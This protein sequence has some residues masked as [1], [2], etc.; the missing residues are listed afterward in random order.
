MRTKSVIIKNVV[1]STVISAIMGFTLVIL[2]SCA[3]S[4]PIKIAY[5]NYSEYVLSS[6]NVQTEK[7]L[8]VEVEVLTPK[9]MYNHPELFSFD[10]MDMPS[11]W[12]LNLSRSYPEGSDG[13]SWLYTLGFGN[14][15]LTAMKVTITNKTGH[16]LRMK[17]SRIYLRIEGEDPIKA[18][19]HYGSS[20]LKEIEVATLTGTKMI[21]LPESYLNEDNSLIHWITHY[22][23]EWDKHRV[24]RLLE[25]S[26]PIGAA[27]QVLSANKK[28]YKLINDVD[29][30]I[31]PDDTYRGI[32]L[33]PVIVSFDQA[34]LKMYDLTT[35]TDA[36]GNPTEKVTFEF[37]LK[38][39]E[40][41]MWYDRD[42][43][44]WREGEPPAPA[45]T[46]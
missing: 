12:R 22:E 2:S 4:G 5:W 33:F 6:Q 21:K 36:A 15:F 31:L 7:G 42:Q 23:N 17:D 26:Y 3:S 39:N 18:L 37:K 24:K 40:D 27:S 11:N 10:L 14:N 13:K 34:T 41:K 38:L 29:R 30:E 35:Q 9:N 44:K 45:Q 25:L 32:L 19:T 1:F 46:S 16:I 43:K 20:R 28:Y 8:T